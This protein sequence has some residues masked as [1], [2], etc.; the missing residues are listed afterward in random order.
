MFVPVLKLDI[1]IGLAVKF[2]LHVWIRSMV[3]GCV[4]ALHLALDL[5]TLSTKL[6]RV[7]M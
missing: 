4:Y 7:F 3:A 2:K 1:Y 5:F 6:L